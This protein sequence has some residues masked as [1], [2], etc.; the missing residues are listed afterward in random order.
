[1]ILGCV[2][3]KATAAAGTVVPCASQTSAIA[4]TRAIT[5]G[6]DSW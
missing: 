1:M 6:G 3:E 2:R 4:R 5:A